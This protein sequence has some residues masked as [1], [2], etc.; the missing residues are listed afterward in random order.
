MTPPRDAFA[1]IEPYRP[2]MRE[3]FHMELAR[4]GTEVAGMCELVAQAMERA[5]QALTDM[6]LTLAEQVI[7]DDLEIDARRAECE[8][9]AFQ[10]LALQAPVA[11][12]LR[13]V[14]S[15]IYAADKVERMGDLARHIADVA[16]R[17]HPQPAVPAEL[18][19]RFA[20]MGKLGA[21][22]ARELGR[23]VVNP[24]TPRSEEMDRADDRTDQ[25]ER[26][27]LATLTSHDCD[28]DV[29]TAVDVALLAR[30]YERFADQAVSVMRRID[31]VVTGEQA[32]GSAVAPP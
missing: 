25:L 5:T 24:T 9:H 28:Y 7:S 18:V 17:R 32:H 26:E 3:P 12:D 30:F 23:V 13:V 1:G 8:D 6:D 21:R 20:E 11:R 15:T 2:P 27:L 31:F 16:R 14:V 22:A 29:R 10:V 4:L 19:G